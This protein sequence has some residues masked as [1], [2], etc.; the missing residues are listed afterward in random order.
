MSTNLNLAQGLLNANTNWVANWG[1]MMA[2]PM[3]GVFPM[4]TQEIDAEGS[5]RIDINFLANH[6]VMQAWNG[7]RVQ[8]NARH[9]NF[10]ISYSKYESTL[11]VQRT[12]LQNDRTGAVE[13]MIVD[14]QAL[15]ITSQDKSVATAFDASTGA[16]PT[17]YDGAALFSTAHVHSGTGSNQANLT[18]GTNLSHAA[19]RAARAAGALFQLEN[20]EPANVIYD[21]IRVGPN[22]FDR[23]RELTSADRVVT[24]KNDG[25]FDAVTSTVAG[26]ATRSNIY[27]GELEVVQDLRVTTYYWTLV[28]RKKTAKPMVVFNARKPEAISRTDM[29]DPH[30]WNMDEFLFGL[31][32]DW[33]VAAGHWHTCY[34]GTGTA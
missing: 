22:L 2:S 16:G 21:M 7:P 3:R 15:A 24:I 14:F 31:E 29:T 23:A 8:K 12:L 13:R 28:D 4:Y 9:Y 33:G 1:E 27:A 17:G 32:G 10:T 11:P 30:R 20:G 34:R 25:A 26:G 18:S 19:L 6:P 5:A